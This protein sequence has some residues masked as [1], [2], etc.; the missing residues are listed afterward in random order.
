MKTLKLLLLFTIVFAGILNSQTVN[1][2]KLDSLFNVLAEK[3]KAMGSFVFSKNGKVIYSRAIGYSYISGNEK[4][5]ATAE[6][7]YRIGS[8]SKM[9]TAV[10]IFQ[11]VQEGK[12]TLETTA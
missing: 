7:K 5:A 3:D 6:T 12:I 8:T 9:F 10:M 2:S 4:K 1:K 11:L